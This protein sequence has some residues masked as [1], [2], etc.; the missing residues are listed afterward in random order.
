[1]QAAQAAVPKIIKAQ[2]QLA[3]QHTSTKTNP[4]SDSQGYAGCD[5]AASA[6]ITALAKPRVA[7]ILGDSHA[8]RS[9]VQ[10]EAALKEAKEEV[11]Q[12]LTQRGVFRYSVGA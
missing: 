4:I 6:S 10:V 11:I 12:Q 3:T 8:D 7:R 5:P 2:Q 9:R 1:M